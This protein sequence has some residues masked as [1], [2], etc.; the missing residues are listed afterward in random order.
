MF[1]IIKIY[2]TCVQLL[3]PL[4]LRFPSQVS[5]LLL[6]LQLLPPRCLCRRVEARRDS[7][8]RGI[9][10]V[11]MLNTSSH[12]VEEEEQRRGGNYI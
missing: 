4:L 11:L 9:R 2:H 5:P 10:R 3:S 1:I 7:R 8:E 6:L 12:K